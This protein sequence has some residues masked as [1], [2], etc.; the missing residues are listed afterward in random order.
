MIITQYK[1][2]SKFFIFLML[3]MASI[4][5]GIAQNHDS[6]LKQSSQIDSLVAM[7][8]AINSID[9]LIPGYR[10]Q[11]FFAGGNFSKNKSIKKLEEFKT[12]HQEHKAYLSFKAPYYRV[13]VG[14]F[15]TNLQATAFLKEIE[16]DYP[17]AF[18]VEDMICFPKI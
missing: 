16:R 8:K 2:L 5:S 7:H 11:I 6:F 3:Y 10:V 9:T 12:Q 1:Y 17:S 18:I 4:A 13:R 15:R 14:D